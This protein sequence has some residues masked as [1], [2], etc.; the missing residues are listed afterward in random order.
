MQSIANLDIEGQQCRSVLQVRD[1]ILVG[2]DKKLFTFDKKTFEKVSE[3]DVESSIYAIVNVNDD[4][5]MIG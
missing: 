2:C 5:I 4:V 1:F 3:L